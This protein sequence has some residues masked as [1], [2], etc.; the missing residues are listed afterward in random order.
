[1]AEKEPKNTNNYC[2]DCYFHMHVSEGLVGFGHDIC[3]LE[4]KKR[5]APNQIA[6][7]KYREHFG[8]E[9]TKKLIEEVEKQNATE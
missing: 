4:S 9:N 7:E 1:M 2:N 3:I 5:H 8:R 6:C